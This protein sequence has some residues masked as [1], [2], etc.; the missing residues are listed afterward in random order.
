MIQK[1]IIITDAI[2][3]IKWILMIRQIRQ[4]DSGQV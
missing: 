4:D 2:L 1:V 3:I